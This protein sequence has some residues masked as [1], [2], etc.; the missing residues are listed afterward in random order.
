MTVNDHTR[1][2]ATGRPILDDQELVRDLTDNELEEELLVAAMA[3][4]RER[5]DRFNTLLEERARRKNQAL[6]GMT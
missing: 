5:I 3:R 6:R 1:D 4:N 2:T